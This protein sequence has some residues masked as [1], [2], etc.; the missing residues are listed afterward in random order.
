MAAT[1]QKNLDLQRQFTQQ[2][3]Q[4]NAGVQALGRTQVN[5]SINA[6]DN[7]SGY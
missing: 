6:T 7:A 1:L 3:A 4:T 2:V 5:T